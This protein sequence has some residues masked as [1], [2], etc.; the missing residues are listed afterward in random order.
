M[1]RTLPA[2]VIASCLAAGGAF[3]Q[4]AAAPVATASGR[5][6][7]DA[8]IDSYLKAA[9]AGSG[10]TQPLDGP[11]AG[12]PCRPEPQRISEGAFDARYPLNRPGSAYGAGYGPGYGEPLPNRPFAQGLDPRPYGRAPGLSDQAVAAPGCA[13]DRR[14]H[15]VVSAGI[16]TGGYRDV[17]ATVVAPLGDAG[18]VGISV[19]SS[20]YGGR[21]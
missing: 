14:L 18:A 19:G 20:H 21:R 15:G 2:L 9:S 13:P 1:S 16:G 5:A 4:T 6:Q 17:S 11:G 12:D 8:A 3:A 7:A 10:D